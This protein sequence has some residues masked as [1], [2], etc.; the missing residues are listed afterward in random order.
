VDDRWESLGKRIR[1]AGREWIPYIVVVGEREE[2]TNTVNVRIRRTNDQKAMTIDELIKMIEE[3][4]KEYPKRMQ[5]LPLLVSQRPP[6]PY[7]M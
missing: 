6:I 7:L 2:K 3:E 1:E 5:T 4:T